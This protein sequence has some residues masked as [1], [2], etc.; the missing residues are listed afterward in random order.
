MILDAD[1][2]RSTS[3]PGKYGQRER[4][5]RMESSGIYV[6]VP[7][8]RA[9]CSFCNFA[10]GVFADGRIDGYVTR[11][12]EEMRGAR[13]FA[14]GLDVD[15]PHRVD[16]IYLGGGT[17]SLLEPEVV[18]RVFAGIRESF[19]VDAG[20]EVTVEGAPGQIA[21]RTLEAM[22]EV[23]VNRLSFGVQSFVD[24]ECAAV[25]RLHTGD[26][27]REEMRRMQAAGVRRLGVDLIVGLPHQTEA[28]WRYTVE[29]AIE[30]G[31]EHVSVYMLEVDDGSRLGRESLRGGVRYGAGALPE[32]DRVADWYAAACEWLEAVGVRQYEISN[33]ARA[34]GE[35]RHNRRYWERRP[36]LGFGLDAHSMLRRGLGGVRWSNADVM[37]EYV[38]L[39][40]AR[41]FVRKIDQV[42]AVA[43]FEEELFLGLRL[44][45]GVDLRGIE[46][47]FRMRPDGLEEL[48]EAGL[49]EVAGERLR[50][51]GRGRMASNEV[52]ERLL[53][54]AAV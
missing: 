32:E 23:G 12:L 16:T 25:G 27:C 17:P 5:V 38:G 22:L 43:G 44:V 45:D 21:E 20:A 10:S 33:F 50:L 28:S 3:I 31:V 29:Q 48:A 18:R 19:A 9:K 34:G 53:V 51:T 54:G 41:G 40:G 36:Y 8:C 14:A 42:D 47:R 52:F 6:S 7:F 49:V 37:D 46:E 1:G 30:S 26:S 24:A 39:M 35:S 2:R 15:V 4:I 13:T 11:L